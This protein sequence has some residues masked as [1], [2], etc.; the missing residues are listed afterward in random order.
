MRSASLC[1]SGGHDSLRVFTDSAPWS[2][3]LLGVISVA[4]IIVAVITVKAVREGRSVE[5]YKWGLK[6][7]PRS[8]QRT[9]Q[10][11]AAHVSSGTDRKGLDERLAVWRPFAVGVN[12]EKLLA[13]DDVIKSAAGTLLSDSGAWA[14]T[15]SGEGG[16]GKTAV[17]YEAVKALSDNSDFT[18][19]VWAAAK[20]A[21][22]GGS[23]AS[24][25]TTTVY[26]ADRLRLSPRS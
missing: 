11:S 1:L 7:G 8:P 18:R 15:L 23:D 14:V 3:V 6:I 12:H 25:G 9:V 4:I 21:V 20:N 5:L 10:P 22:T 2:Y 16:R 26:W 13:V 19:I 24:T 17:A